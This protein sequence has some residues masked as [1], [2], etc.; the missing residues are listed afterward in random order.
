MSKFFLGPSVLFSI[1][2]VYDSLP[3]DIFWL[4]HLHAFERSV[5]GV[6][7]QLGW[8]AMLSTSGAA[9]FATAAV[10]TTVDGGDGGTQS[11]VRHG[12][13]PA[14]GGVFLAFYFGTR[15]L[16]SLYQAR[17]FLQRHSSSVEWAVQNFT[18][19]VIA[20]PGNRIS[21]EYLMLTLPY[22]WLKS[23]RPRQQDDPFMRYRIHWRRGITS[24][25]RLVVLY[26]SIPLFVVMHNP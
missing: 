18:L 4:D 20:F 14:D 11:F 23:R 12:K 6:G 24:A 13:L 25:R 17:G 10:R 7:G 26:K 3:R 2:F 1:V 16:Q 22:P 5:P 19:S 9:S 21:T 8:L 15:S